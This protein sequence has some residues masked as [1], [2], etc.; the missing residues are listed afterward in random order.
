[1]NTSVLFTLLQVFFYFYIFYL[2]HRVLCNKN[3]VLLKLNI[4][5]S[6]LFKIGLAET[7]SPSSV[8]FCF[9][10]NLFFNVVRYA[11]CV[12]VG[13]SFSLFLLSVNT[14]LSS[15]N[16]DAYSKSVS[17][18]CWLLQSLLYFFPT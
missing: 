5:T 6:G 11:M 18:G 8:Y 17:L 12:N 7:D 9:V 15:S 16:F 10:F 4:L 14:K 3:I 13:V 1:M 2:K